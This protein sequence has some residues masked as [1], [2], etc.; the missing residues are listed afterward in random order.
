M[1]YIYI[2]FL[3]L[4]FF[5]CE[6]K[7]VEY[8]KSGKKKNEYILKDGKKEGVYKEFYSN[9]NL[10]VIHNFKNNVLIDSSIYFFKKNTKK[11]FIRFWKENNQIYEI[12]YDTLGNIISKGYLTN[13]F[14]RINKW[15]EYGNNDLLESIQEYVIVD[16]KQYLNQY[17]SLNKNRDTLFYKSNFF[18]IALSNDTITKGKPYKGILY[19]DAPFFKDKNSEIEL[20]IYKSNDKGYTS[21]KKEVVKFYNLFYDKENKKWFPM[22]D[23]KRTVA[24]WGWADELGKNTIKG[25]ILEKYIDKIKGKIEKRK[26]YFEFSIVLVDGKN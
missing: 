18:K 26:L 9:G 7:T 19:L 4:L 23:M 16:N 22:A 13:D 12:N 20:F 25:Y 15:E 14:N 3:Y 17:W 8:Y 6:N 2:V 21:E 24:F 10:K 11:K 5:S 1:K